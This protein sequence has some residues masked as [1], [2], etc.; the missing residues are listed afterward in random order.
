MKKLLFIVFISLFLG[1][2][3]NNAWDCFQTS[4][5]IVQQEFVLDTFTNIIVWD[6]VKLY[7][8]QGPKQKVVVQTGE[9]L[10]NEIRVRVE[11]SI[12]KISDRNSCNFVRDHETT[13]VY[14]TTPELRKIRNSSGLTVENIGP[15]RF[16]EIDL[17][18]E[19]REEE[20]EFH[21]DGDFK[22]DQLDVGT[23]RV[24]ANGLST[25]YLSGKAHNGIF[26]LFDGDARIEAENFEVEDIQVFHRSTNKMIIFPTESVRGTIVSVGDVICKNRP[27]VVE[28][29][30]LYSGKLIFE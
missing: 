4:G 11:D 14:V 20:D 6:R 26:G 25:F 28:V 9:N 23:L 1:C 21:I 8:S 18:A 2:N 19:D 13:K 7:I 5:E 30:E 15:I 10:F 22:M 3:S 17:V 29:E 24:N 27:P 16:E 12:L